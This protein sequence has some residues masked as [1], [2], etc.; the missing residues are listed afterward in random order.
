[1]FLFYRFCVCGFWKKKFKGNYFNP[2]N[3][4]KAPQKMWTRLVQPFLRLLNLNLQICIYIY[5]IYI[6]SV[7]DIVKVYGTC[8][9]Q[10]HTVTHTHTGCWVE[11]RDL[12]ETNQNL[13]RPQFIINIQQEQ[14]WVCKQCFTAHSAFSCQEQ[15]NF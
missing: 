15:W 3:L 10:T 1:M 7:C 14:T 9:T 6:S 13:E 4:C 12:H 5:T 11:S 8:S 2:D